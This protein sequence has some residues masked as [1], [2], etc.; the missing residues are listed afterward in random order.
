M[1]GRVREV[2]AD[3]LSRGDLEGVPDPVVDDAQPQ[4]VAA[5]HQHRRAGP[6]QHRTVV[7]L[8]E[9]RGDQAVLGSRQVVHAHPD[10]TG[11]TLDHPQQHGRRVHAEFVRAGTLLG[12]ERVGDRDA[13]LRG[14]VHGP[15]H[16][17]VPLV[18]PLHPA[19][20]DRPEPPVTAGRVE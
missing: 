17:R 13:A 10:P 1:S 2:E 8:A 14:V 7:L 12:G 19:G 4:P 9:V 16:E 5:Q 3:H 20:S 18:R 15:Q 11:E 6:G